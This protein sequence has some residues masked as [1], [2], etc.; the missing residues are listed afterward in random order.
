MFPQMSPDLTGQGQMGGT[1]SPMIAQNNQLL[2][3]NQ[4]AASQQMP[5]MNTTAPSSQI[6]HPAVQNMIKAL[7]GGT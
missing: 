6:M 3:Q 2:G 4:L 5:Q 7:K 1:T